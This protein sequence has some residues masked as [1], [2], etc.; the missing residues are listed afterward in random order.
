MKDKRHAFETDAIEVT[1]SQRRCIHAA[2]CV[3]RLPRV[4]QPGE[5]PWIKLDRGE[6][7]AVAKVV[8]LCPTGALQYVRRDGGANEIP[9]AQNLVRVTANGPTYLRGDI[10]VIA[11]DGSVLL[12]DTRVAL[13]RC[14]VSANK[15]LCDNAHR[16]TG[17]GDSGAITDLDSV[18]DL[19][20]GGSTLRVRPQ[21][22]G[23]I[24]LDGPFTLASSD[25]KTI[26]SGTSAWLCRCGKS[27]SKPFCDGSHAAG[28]EAEGA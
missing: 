7:D 12:K 16:T 15:P 17:F 19:G 23:P 18:E 13:C 24:H 1:W 28:F 10:E 9:A 21:L 14:G 4:F 5:Q 25:G 6:A 11:P 20:S 3:R 27:G 2:E 22:N 26:L 8:E